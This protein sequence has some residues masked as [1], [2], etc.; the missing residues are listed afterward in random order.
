MLAKLFTLVS[1]IFLTDL[2]AK[3]IGWKDGANLLLHC[4]ALY[5]NEV[6]PRK[7]RPIK[8]RLYHRKNLTLIGIFTDYIF[9]HTLQ[10]CLFP[11]NFE[12]LIFFQVI[13]MQTHV[14]GKGNIFLINLKPNCYWKIL[15]DKPLKASVAPGALFLS[16]WNWSANFRYCFLIS[17][18]PA[19][20]ETPKIS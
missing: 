14:K 4:F 10:T 3:I 20:L 9:K 18:S 12:I 5:S 1:W 19:S 8:N 11:F 2:F 6:M 17:D 16:G 7:S 13:H 15:S